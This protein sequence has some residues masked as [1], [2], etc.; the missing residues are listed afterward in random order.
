M[1]QYYNVKLVTF[2]S[3]VFVV[4]RRS[5]S[6]R[7]GMRRSIGP[8][9]WSDGSRALARILHPGSFQIVPDIVESR[10]ALSGRSGRVSAFG[11]RRTTV[12]VFGTRP[13]FGRLLPI[14]WFLAAVHVTVTARASIRLVT[15]S[16]VIVVIPARWIGLVRFRCCRKKNK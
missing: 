5:I 13:S 6:Q 3:D 9:C 7:H 16:R 2:N 15:P 11:T 14:C 1:L 12:S 8:R 4:K 10:C